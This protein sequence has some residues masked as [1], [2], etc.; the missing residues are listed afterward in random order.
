M[1]LV[2]KVFMNENSFVKFVK[3]SPGKTHYTLCMMMYTCMY[4]CVYTYI[5][6]YHMAGFFLRG[7][8]FTNCQGHLIPI[9]FSATVVLSYYFVFATLYGI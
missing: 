2:G 1:F 4:M 5:C 6:I 9:N 3:I 8:F 7:K